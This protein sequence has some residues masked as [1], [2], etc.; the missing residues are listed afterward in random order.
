MRTNQEILREYRNIQKKAMMRRKKFLL[1]FTLIGLLS[2]GGFYIFN[3]VAT[4][5]EWMLTKWTASFIVGKKITHKFY[6][7]RGA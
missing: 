4:A 2:L 3:F 7:L 6:S 1:L 5:P